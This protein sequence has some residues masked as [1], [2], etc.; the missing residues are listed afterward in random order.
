VL[1]EIKGPTGFSTHMFLH[2]DWSVSFVERQWSTGNLSLDDVRL[3]STRNFIG[4]VYDIVLHILHFVRKWFLSND[5]SLEFTMLFY[6]VKVI[7]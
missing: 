3:F 7:I 5:L 6:P 2:C 1:Q 4:N